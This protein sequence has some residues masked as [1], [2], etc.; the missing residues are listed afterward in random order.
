[1]P[2]RDIVQIARLIAE[3][4]GEKLASHTGNEK[5]SLRKE[6]TPRVRAGV[7]FIKN[8]GISIAYNRKDRSVYIFPGDARPS[9][10][11]TAKKVGIGLAG[12][13]V[14]AGIGL[15]VVMDE[16]NGQN[17]PIVP[18]YSYKDLFKKDSP[19]PARVASSSAESQTPEAS[20]APLPAPP[21]PVDDVAPGVFVNP[22]TGD[23]H[24]SR[25]AALKDVRMDCAA[26]TVDGVGN[27]AL[28]S[29]HVQVQTDPKSKGTKPLIGMPYKDVETLF[30]D[31]AQVVVKDPDSGAL[32]SV[33]VA[34][35]PSLERMEAFL[36]GLKLGPKDIKW[37][38]TTTN[39]ASVAAAQ[40]FMTML[41]CG[42]RIVDSR[43]VDNTEKLGQE[44]GGVYPPGYALTDISLATRTPYANKVIRGAELQDNQD[45]QVYVRVVLRDVTDEKTGEVKPSLWIGHTAAPE[46]YEDH[47]TDSYLGKALKV[48]REDGNFSADHGKGA[49]EAPHPVATA[50]M[51]SRPPQSKPNHPYYETTTIPEPGSLSLLAFGLAALGGTALRR[52]SQSRP[53]ESPSADPKGPDLTL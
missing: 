17:G 29:P 50:I 43:I 46:K 30:K 8:Q 45:Q 35:I 10:L 49:I 39:P 42:E 13:A 2:D 16:S 19:A 52:R 25:F 38:Q 41:T 20:D 3:P 11:T 23:E 4:P 22:A 32:K 47:L 7:A 27:M 48:A 53:E 31:N 26:A 12:L 18:K 28:L 14:A 15:N 24:G 37:G 33:Y 40:K 34:Y 9:V 5:A 21:R 51:V 44:K 1:M 6:Y 36:S